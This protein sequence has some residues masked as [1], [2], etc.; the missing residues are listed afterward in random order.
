MLPKIEIL[1]IAKQQTS[2]FSLP[3]Y[4]NKYVLQFH[5]YLYYRVTKF[6]FNNLLKISTCI[7]IGKDYIIS[8]YL[9]SIPLFL[10]SLFQIILQHLS[11]HYCNYLS[12][13]TKMVS[14][15][16]E[17]SLLSIKTVIFSIS[18]SLFRLISILKSP[19]STQWR[20]KVYVH[21]DSKEKIRP[22]KA[23]YAPLSQVEASPI[24][25]LE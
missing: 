6:L 10:L 1:K 9:F 13:L 19:D 17:M 3:C 16:I 2:L 8:H 20:Q 15:D 23:L 7:K 5:I 25:Y 18:L 11:K 24:R 22:L 14:P 4:R 21:G 12:S